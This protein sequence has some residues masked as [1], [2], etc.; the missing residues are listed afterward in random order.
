[1]LMF[2]N[3]RHG[4]AIEMEAKKRK[5]HNCEVWKKG[6]LKIEKSVRREFLLTASA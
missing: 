4:G 6:F 5:T 1:M 2:R 3:R